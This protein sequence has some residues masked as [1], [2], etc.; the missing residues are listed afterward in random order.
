MKKTIL[1][2]F[3]GLLSINFQAQHCDIYFPLLAN[4]GVQYQS[5]NNK[6]KL[7][8]IQD[9]IVQSVLQLPTHT[10]AI[11]LNTFYDNKNNITKE[12]E[13]LVK[14]K[15]N[16]I[17]LDPQ[18]VLDQSMFDGFNNMQN[19]EVTITPIEI[20]FPSSLYV[21]MQLP[22]ASL[23]INV[24]A[25]GVQSMKTTFTVKNR[26]V[27]SI[28][29]INT[30]IGSFECFKITSEIESVSQ[31]MGFT[32][33]MTAY[34]IDYWTKGLGTVKS[35]SYNNKNRLESYMLINKIY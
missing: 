18:S 34:S 5:F 21:G 19:M 22:E 13:L 9:L 31:I 7:I 23:V 16:E 28:E 15:N 30:P 4:K 25:S 6:H 20:V 32:R 29:T 33:S 27:E 14:C 35:E 1:L 8:G 17:W 26:K 2:T 10:E 24:S 11:V 12:M 3:F